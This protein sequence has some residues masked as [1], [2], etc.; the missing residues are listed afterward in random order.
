MTTIKENGA[1][2]ELCELTTALFP[3]YGARPAAFRAA[4]AQRPDLAAVAINPCGEPVIPKTAGGKTSIPVPDASAF[5]QAKPWSEVL[6]EI[7]GTKATTEPGKPQVQ[8]GALPWSQVLRSIE[9]SER[10]AK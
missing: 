6:R 7:A 9:A 10:P 2:L 8:G 5:G 1:W 3:R 4:C